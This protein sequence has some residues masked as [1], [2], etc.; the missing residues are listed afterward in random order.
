MSILLAGCLA[1]E[2]R[3]EKSGDSKEALTL[4]K[5][6]LVEGDESTAT[7][8]GEETETDIGEVFEEDEKVE[9]LGDLNQ[10]ELIRIYGI[11][12]NL[13]VVQTLF[14][15][16]TVDTMEYNGVFE[17][18]VNGRQDNIHVQLKFRNTTL[19][20]SVLEV[21]G[22]TVEYEFFNPYNI[23]FVDLDKADDSYE[24]VVRDDGPSDDP[25]NVV[26]RYTGQSL[27]YLGEIA[28]YALLD[29]QGNLVTEY[30]KLFDPPLVFETASVDDDGLQ[31]RSV[32]NVDALTA[33]YKIA[34][35]FETYFAT[36]D[37]VNASSILNF[38]RDVT[39][40]EKG[41]NVKIYDY[42]L[43]DFNKLLWFDIELD[44]VRGYMYFY[45][46]D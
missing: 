40:I 22:R 19:R 10:Y 46:G 6:V 14:S 11:E 41:S 37:E 7:N 34:H 3:S 12:H 28:P 32:D 18:G 15:D 17:S 24:L 8:E 13:D 21:N 39:Y 2:V 33:E 44:G 36:A 16:G 26:F 42:Q 45:L 23:H 29:G 30:F 25:V 31:S 27:I 1:V 35:S 43:D 5:S 20:T 38:D 9:F 4:E